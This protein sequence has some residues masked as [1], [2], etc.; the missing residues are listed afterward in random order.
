MSYLQRRESSSSPQ[1]PCGPCVESAEELRRWPA[2]LEFLE[3]ELWPDGTS[4]VAGTLL[5]FVER[6]KLKACLSDRDQ[7]LVCFVTAASVVDL[8]DAAEKT[9]EGSNGDWRPQRT[10]P[11]GRG[12]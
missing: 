6:G 10:K 2:L 8:V 12:R 1:G 4:R 11:P 5:V 7:G 3:A 9:L